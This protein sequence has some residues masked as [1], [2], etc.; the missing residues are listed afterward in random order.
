MQT[1]A[2]VICLESDSLMVIFMVTD[3]LA[4]GWADPNEEIISSAMRILAAIFFILL[5]NGNRIFIHSDNR[6]Q[7]Q[8]QVYFDISTPLDVLLKRPST[9]LGV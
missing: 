6:I 5:W 7:D 8:I 4:G 3:L 9:P 1:I 2:G